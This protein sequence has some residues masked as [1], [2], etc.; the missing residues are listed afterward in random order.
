M[1]LNAPELLR[2]LEI[3]S[4]ANMHNQNVELNEDL[5]TQLSLEYAKKSVIELGELKSKEEKEKTDKLQQ[6][7][8]FKSPT[9][10]T[11]KL[12]HIKEGDLRALRKCGEL[13][14]GY[15]YETGINPKPSAIFYDLETTCRQLH[16]ISWEEFSKPGFDIQ[17]NTHRKIER[18]FERARKGMKK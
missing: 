17:A 12:L 9:T 14:R 5:F 6:K 11:S 16:D 3:V 10:V 13:K 4:Q 8:S 18:A 1:N 15:H 7:F 2:L